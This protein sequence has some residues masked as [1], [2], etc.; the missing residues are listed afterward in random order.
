MNT[1]PII[2]VAGLPLSYVLAKKLSAFDLVQCSDPRPDLLPVLASYYAINQPEMA[3]SIA[4][5]YKNY[6]DMLQVNWDRLYQVNK[7]NNVTINN[8]NGTNWQ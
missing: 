7:G 8:V 3:V 2:K 6:P 4:R 5:Q 1:N